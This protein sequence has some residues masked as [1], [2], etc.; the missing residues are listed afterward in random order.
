MDG[1]LRD[2]DNHRRPDPNN[3]D[4]FRRPNVPYEMVEPYRDGFRRG[5][6]IEGLLAVLRH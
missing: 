2:L 1:A 3:R 4:E 6:K 5:Y